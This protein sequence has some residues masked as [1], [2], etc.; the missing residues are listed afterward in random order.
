[1]TAGASSPLAC[2]SLSGEIAT[3]AKVYFDGKC[4]SH[5]VTMADGSKKSVGVVLP[6]TLN[7]GTGAPE[8]MEVIDGACRV[9]LAGS[10]DWQ[11]FAA[12][13]SFKVP[14]DS[15]FDIEVTQTLH[16]VCHFG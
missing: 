7:F 15:S 14:G 8:T 10:A 13:Q 9:K 2:G 6:A 11:S 3:Q 4:I 16:Y 12:G 5:S 1:M